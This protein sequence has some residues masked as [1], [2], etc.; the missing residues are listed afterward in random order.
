MRKHWWKLCSFLCLLVVFILG[1][2]G[3][4]PMLDIVE[5]SI[6][7]LYFHVAMW[8]SMMVLFTVSFVY[9]IRYLRTFSDT[10]DTTSLVFA[11]IGVAVGFLGL[12]TGALWAKYTWGAYWSNDPKQIGAAIALAMY[13]AYLTLR[14][15]VE[16]KNKMGHICAVYNVF[17]F[18]LLFP[19]LWILP[20]LVN[21]LHPGGKSNPVF[22]PKDAD[23]NMRVVF[24][25]SVIGWTLL[26]VWIANIDLRYHR[27]K[28][29]RVQT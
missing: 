8:M 25:L 6:R 26:C 29:N 13:C 11:R 17:S 20:R 9:A 5:Q 23:W 19:T 1:F 22:N 4:V 28:R 27:I 24:Y 12:I 2:L 7:N 3:P 10:E 18:F 16:D 14:Q 21:S 15:S